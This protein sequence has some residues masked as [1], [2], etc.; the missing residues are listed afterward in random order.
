[1]R[2][3]KRVVIGLMLAAAAA[4]LVFGPRG[5]Q[6]IPPGRVVVD[7]WEKWT[8]NE[9]AQMASIVDDFNRTVGAQKGIFVRFV[10][11]SNIDQKTL[12]AV[13]AGVPPDVTG[14]WD[15]NLAQY[16]AQQAL[17]PL[18]DLAKSHGITAATY[19][20]VYWDACHWDGHLY[21]LVSTPATISLIYNKRLFREHADK[22]RAA[23]CDP[24][25][26]PRT[27]QE[28][29]RYAA[30]LD[31]KDAQGHLVRMGILPAAAWYVQELPFWF[32]GDLW[33]ARHERFT[34]TSPASVA[35]FTWVQSFSKRLGAGATTDFKTGMGTYDSPQ[36]PFIAG[37]EAMEQQGPWIANIMLHQK[38]SMF[39]VRAEAD[40]DVSR[41]AAERRAACEWGAAPFP[42]AVP[43]LENVCYAPF[44]L[45]AIPVGAKHVAEAFEFIAYVNAQPVMEKI[46]NLHSENSPLTAVSEHFL[47]HHKNPY[48]DV[49]DALAASPNA[50]ALPQVP[51]WPEVNDELSD[52]IQQLALLTAEPEPALAAAQGRLQAKYDAFMAKQRARTMAR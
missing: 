51:I 10:S 29:D 41:P 22:L 42:S 49:Y 25:R 8:G 39:G 26:P 17:V 12:A 13:A 47:Q 36:N 1:M 11:T 33:D 18:D 21:C 19:K 38:P 6:D 4:V 43:G 46:C 44:D 7:Y 45:L 32:G 2:W 31:E 52:V 50:K 23:G 30:A 24:D 34:L 27:L 37:T 40:Y 15:R 20:K 9:G 5:D 14:M 3:V 35:A 48:I 16:A 28:L